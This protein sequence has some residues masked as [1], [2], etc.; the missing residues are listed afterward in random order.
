VVKETLYF[1]TESRE[2]DVWVFDV[3]SR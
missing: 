1:V 2:S 3:P